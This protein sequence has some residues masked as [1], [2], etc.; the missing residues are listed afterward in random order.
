VEESARLGRATD[1]RLKPKRRLSSPVND[2]HN[3]LEGFPQPEEPV[4]L[5]LL[6]AQEQSE[7]A[8]QG[9]GD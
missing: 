4:K 2:P 6:H 8:P 7:D 3:K 9:H 5:E 1:G